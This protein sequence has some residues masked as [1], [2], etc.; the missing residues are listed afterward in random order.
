M[1]TLPTPGLGKEVRALGDPEQRGLHFSAPTC[2]G[3][4]RVLRR[5]TPLPGAAGLRV[6]R[7]ALLAQGRDVSRAPAREMGPPNPR[8]GA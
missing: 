4:H 1:S 2:Q 6:P 7:A 8:L 3:P 5:E